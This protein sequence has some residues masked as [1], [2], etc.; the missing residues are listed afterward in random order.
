MSLG[1]TYIP[2]FAIVSSTPYCISA[3]LLVYLLAWNLKSFK[4]DP[5]GESPS[6][7]PTELIISVGLYLPSASIEYL[8][9]SLNFA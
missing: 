2:Q 9:L 7:I 4:L 6:S 1:Q 5:Y 8:I 3:P